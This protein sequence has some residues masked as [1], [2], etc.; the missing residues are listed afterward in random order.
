MFTTVS[1]CQTNA[2]SNRRYHCSLRLYGKRRT[3]LRPGVQYL[4]R[5]RMLVITGLLHI[6]LR[7]FLAEFE[8][9][10]DAKRAADRNR[11]DRDG[12]SSTDIQ[13]SPV[14]E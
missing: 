13:I 8:K 11:K 10:Q 9:E 1:N 12:R 4:H 6:P 14:G 3:E 5:L 2:S 7:L